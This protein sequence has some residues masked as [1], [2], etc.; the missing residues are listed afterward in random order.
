MERPRVL[1]DLDQVVERGQGALVDL[2]EPWHHRA[3]AVGALGAEAGARG[4]DL[5]ST[6]W[7]TSAMPISREVSTIARL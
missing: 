5:A 1:G 6:A 3:E 2:G 4:L 7:A